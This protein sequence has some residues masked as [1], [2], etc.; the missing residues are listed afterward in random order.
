VVILGS[1]VDPT[2]YESEVTGLLARHPGASYL[3]TE[4]SC[5]SLRQR[6]DGNLIYA[7][8][9]GPFPSPDAA[10]TTRN[11]MG[12]DSY[13]KRLDTTTPADRLWSC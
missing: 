5:S 4:G 10:C 9:L 3:L 2:A 7:V 1:A 11:R 8:Y 13:V 6:V 12:A